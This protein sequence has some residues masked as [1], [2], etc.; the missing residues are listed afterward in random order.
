MVDCIGLYSTR[1]ATHIVF[2]TLVLERTIDKRFLTHNTLKR[3]VKHELCV[4]AGDVMLSLNGTL[5]AIRVVCTSRLIMFPGIC[6]L[7]SGHGSVQYI[8]IFSRSQGFIF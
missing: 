4:L 6:V 5:K 2:N 3:L 8:T 1:H 7:I